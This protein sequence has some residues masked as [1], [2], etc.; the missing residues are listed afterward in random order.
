MTKLYVILLFFAITTHAQNPS[1]ELAQSNLPAIPVSESPAL[2]PPIKEVIPCDQ[3][4]SHMVEYQKKVSAAENSLSTFLN[5]VSERVSEW[6]ELL[7]PLEGSRGEIPAGQFAPLKD[8]AEKISA[9]A[10][11]ALENTDV[12]TTELSTILTSL[13]SCSIASTPA[14]GDRPL[15]TPRP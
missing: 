14:P 4:M 11:Q 10:D 6:Y 3:I 9:R 5:Q 8:G 1:P 15:S 12:L 2:P 7:Q 13:R